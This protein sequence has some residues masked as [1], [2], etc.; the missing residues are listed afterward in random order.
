MKHIFKEQS[1]ELTYKLNN[2]G[3]KSAKIA[4]H[5]FGQY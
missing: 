4:Y 1:G 3:Y 2:T 5:R